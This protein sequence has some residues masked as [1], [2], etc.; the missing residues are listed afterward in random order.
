[1]VIIA[2]GKTEG[3]NWAVYGLRAV[4]LDKLSREGLPRSW[5]LSKDQKE[6]KEKT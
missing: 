3:R 1:M 5:Y 2:I 6:M 4:S